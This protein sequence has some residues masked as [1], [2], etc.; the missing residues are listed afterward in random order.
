[1]A[2]YAPNVVAT[3]G[4]RVH[5]YVDRLESYLVRDCTI[6]SLNKYM[7]IARMQGFAQKLEDQRQRKRTQES[8]IGHSKRDRSMAST[9]PQFQGSRGNQFGQRGESQGSRIAGYQ[10]QGSM[11][12]SRPPR[13]FCKQY[14]RNHLGA[15]R[16][17][18]NACFWCGT[19]G[20]MMRN[21]PHRGVGGVAQPTRSVV[22]PRHQH[23]F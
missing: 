7:A 11:S 16:F 20:H 14:G 9:P 23:L 18:T 21:C 22:H 19:P 17:G 15:C 1:M 13:E 10:E 3:M 6:A 2:R 4:D 5:R 12:Q 8:E